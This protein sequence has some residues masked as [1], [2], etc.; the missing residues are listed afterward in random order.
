MMKNFIT[1]M[2]EA[3]K[4]SEMSVSVYKTAWYYFSEDSRIHTRRR[5]DLEPGI[6]NHFGS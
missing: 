6:S 2:A 3:V 5:K 4:F 1:L